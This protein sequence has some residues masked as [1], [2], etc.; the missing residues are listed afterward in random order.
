MNLIASGIDNVRACVVLAG[1]GR[2]GHCVDEPSS[3]LVKW[4]ST[5]TDKLY[6]VYVNGRFAGVTDGCKDR[7]MRVR[8][9]SCWSSVSRID[10]FAVAPEFGQVDLSDDAGLEKDGGRVELVWSRQQRLPFGGSYDVYMDSEGGGIDSES[11]PLAD[12]VAIW[13]VWQEKGGFGLSRFGRSDFG[14]DGSA[15]VGFGRGVFGGG[16]FGFDA[17]EIRWISDEIDSGRY[18]FAV[19]V[20]DRAGNTYAE[21]VSDEA[22]VVRQAKGAGRLRLDS[23]DKSSGAISFKV[24]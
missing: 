3:V 19:R 24:E 5:H 6:Q 15:C 14:F 17:D 20:A 16:E 21:M 9:L 12:D 18:E 1:V 11:N 23:Y 4:R 22:L 8:L 13:P 10:V 7:S 2:G